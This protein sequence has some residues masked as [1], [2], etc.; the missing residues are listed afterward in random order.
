VREQAGE[1]ALRRAAWFGSSVR[2]NF[3]RSSSSWG[4]IDVTALT[5]DYLSEKFRQPLIR[6]AEP[7]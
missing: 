1:T 2:R 7:V 3:A 4:D 6:I 5:P